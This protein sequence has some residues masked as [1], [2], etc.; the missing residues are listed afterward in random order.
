M[1]NAE[2]NVIS[3]GKGSE[4]RVPGVCGSIGSYHEIPHSAFRIPNSAFRIPPHPPLTGGIHA[5][6]ASLGMTDRSSAYSELTA[7]TMLF[8]ASASAGYCADIAA[9]S[10]ATVAAAGRS[11][12]T[13]SAPASCLATANSL[14]F[15]FIWNRKVRTSPQPPEPRTQVFTLLR[16]LPRGQ[17][18]AYQPPEA[19]HTTGPGA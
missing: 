11:T 2:F 1:R 17:S 5:T 19:A 14:T 13:T 4:L 12:E 6:S 16:A 8:I 18:I 10:V 15:S 9:R 7:N 3:R